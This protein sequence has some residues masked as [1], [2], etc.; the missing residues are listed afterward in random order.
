[1][2]YRLI[3]R[4]GSGGM[5]EVFRATGVGPDGFERAFIIKRIHPRLS[6]APEFV[7]MF[8]H[9]AKILARLIH[10]NIVQVFELAYHDGAHY[11]VMEPVEG[12]DMSW[13]LRRRRERPHES[14]SPAFVA[15]VARQ[16][17]RGLEY[18][19]TLKTADGEPMG[20]VH[21]D[22]T[23]PN[24]MVAWNG[25]VKILD[26]GIARAAEAIRPSLTDPG[27]VKGKMSYVAPEL[28]EGAT[29]D[30]R[31]DLFSLGAVMHELLT[32]EPLFTGQTDLETLNQVQKKAIPPPSKLNPGVKPALDA[33]VMKA[34]ARDPE[35]RYGSA[36]EMGDELEA[37]VL[38]KNYST[39]ALA[40]KARELAQEEG[41]TAAI[42]MIARATPF[43]TGTQAEAIAQPVG[44][45]GSGDASVFVEE[46][47]GRKNGKGQ[48]PAEPMGT[49]ARFAA[50]R[51]AR[52][53]KAS[54]RKGIV[55]LAAGCLVVGFAVGALTLRPS[56]VTTGPATASSAEVAPGATAR[57]TLDSAPQGATVVAVRDGRRLGE[58]PLQ[59]DL[60]RSQEA[61][62]LTL[63]KVGFA[64]LPFKVIPNQDKD[65]VAQLNALAAPPPPAPTAAAIPRKAET[66]FKAATKLST[67]GVGP[68][69][70]VAP[71]PP[72]P[73][74]AAPAPRPVASTA[75]AAIP[76][77]PT[78]PAASA[79]VR[80]NAPAASSGPR[81]LKPG[82]V[83]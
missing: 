53:N 52:A 37:L 65:V 9:E 34:L 21:R 72:R 78:T 58:T 2:K 25:T 4:I 26:F 33:V 49:P 18:A 60:P 41:T 71:A 12:M 8:V 38:R 57:V 42:G 20:I 83:R 29:A 23:P 13:L 63:T 5:A 62:E 59:L 30:P 6:Q 50:A 67:T 51:A 76:R 45:I 16:V 15:E 31:C 77:G 79:P 82:A 39:R 44:G 64:P 19:H 14:L 46:S 28:L 47:R 75:A 24:I 66:P 61:I 1:M 69:P 27:I 43:M 36:E 11:M 56:A 22:V 3:E 68:R 48:A 10:P 40:R 80:T 35:K 81:P 7:S 54:A 55:V 70:S 74:A 32:G 73:P 17:C